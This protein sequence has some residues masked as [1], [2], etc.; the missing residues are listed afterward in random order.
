MEGK[1]GVGGTDRES[2]W[3]VWH[4]FIWQQVDEQIFAY[5]FSKVLD[6]VNI[7]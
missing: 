3:R 7:C 4:S 5:P 6:K 2:A 1:V